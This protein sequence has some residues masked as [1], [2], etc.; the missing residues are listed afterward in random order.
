[1]LAEKLNNTP[2]N[3]MAQ[4]V[5]DVVHLKNEYAQT[6]MNRNQIINKDFVDAVIA[7][8]IMSYSGR[9]P[10][11]AIDEAGNFCSTDLDLLSFL[12]P[13]AARRAVIEIPE[14]H[15]RRQ[16]VKRVGERKVGTNQFG[17][18][19]SLVS[20]KDVFSFSVKIHDKTKVI[21]DYETGQEDI[22]AFRNYMLVDYDGHWYE[23]WDRI[24]WDPNAEEN[25]FLLRNQLWNE[26]SVR[27][28]YYVHP[29]RWQSIYGA[30]YLL[31]KMLIER[32]NDEAAF[33]KAE[34]QRLMA[35][36]IKFPKGERKATPS[37]IISGPTEEVSVTAMNIS[38]SIPEFTGSYTPVANTQEGLV[39]AYRWQKKLTYS[40]RPTVQFLVRAD[41]AAFL[42]FGNA[43]PNP[44]VAH[45]MGDYKW[46]P[47][48]GNAH[49]VNSQK[50]FLSQDMSL[51]C[52]IKT[53]TEKV[54][55]L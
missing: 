10:Q 11:P 14:Y 2:R 15:K 30:P 50:M 4:T 7:Q 28:K 38:L 47:Y 48:I 3:K 24:V 32:L 40:L 13:L 51:T 17:P 6:I 16:V 8:G 19:I 33:Y 5:Y 23:N 49:N 36:G 43:N 35:S 22:G 25:F 54:S 20:N 26:N 18:L 12:V 52:N 9:T 27:F 53:K 39:Q 45:W 37:T 29:N 55:A 1:M 44:R 42:L 41:E 46:L 21:K 34:M 31:N